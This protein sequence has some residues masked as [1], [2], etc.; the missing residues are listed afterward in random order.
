[1]EAIP[2]DPVVRIVPRRGGAGCEDRAAQGR[3]RMRG[4]EAADCLSPR[5]RGSA[6][7]RSGG[8]NQLTRSRGET[9]AIV[10]SSWTR[11]GPKPLRVELSQARMIARA[12]SMIRATSGR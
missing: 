12:A 3:G 10:A 7:D 1:M 11:A 4:R 6:C 8:A 5:L 2:V 9:E